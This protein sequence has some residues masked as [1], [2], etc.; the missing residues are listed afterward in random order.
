MYKSW[1][2]ARV[3]L[4]VAFGEYFIYYDPVENF[5]GEDPKVA[6]S[7]DCS[8]IHLV[9][10]SQLA[11]LSDWHQITVLPVY[12]KEVEREW[13]RH[14]ELVLR[15]IPEEVWT[16]CAACDCCWKDEL[17]NQDPFHTHEMTHCEAH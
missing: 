8:N 7:S 17:N 12:Q 14:Q 6:A 11:G 15:S 2:R 5:E 4:P 9:S 1:S 13:N 10:E 16:E 3:C